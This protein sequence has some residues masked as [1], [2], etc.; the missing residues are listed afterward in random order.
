MKYVLF[1]CNHNAGRS[2][3]AQALF[4][5]HAP[6]DVRAESAGSTPAA[7]VWP[8]VVQVMGEM[9]FDLSDRRPRKLT[10]E[11]QL[12]ADWAITMGCGDACPYVPTTVEDWD[13]PDPA[14]LSIEEVRT[15]RDAIDA[16]IRDLVETKLD[17]IRSDRTA[18]QLRLTRLLPDLTK[19][20]EGVRTPEEIRACADAILGDYQAAP[21]RSFVMSIAHKRTRE[22]LRA[23][24]CDAVATAG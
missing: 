4:E 18:H 19:E 10:V 9:G 8:N 22:C 3:M 11:M 1:V 13:I 17:A 6:D 21:V 15:I 16:R 7:Q 12:H 24:H 23:E 2:Q 14:H 20:F 5:T